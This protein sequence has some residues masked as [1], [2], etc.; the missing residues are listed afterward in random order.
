M[1]KSENKPNL[2]NI[3]DELPDPAK[4]EKPQILEA[5]HDGRFYDRNK[6][7]KSKQS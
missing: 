7:R 6:L 4:T 3:Y 1:E 5:W 2:L